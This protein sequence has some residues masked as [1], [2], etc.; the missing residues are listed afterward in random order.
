MRTIEFLQKLFPI[1]GEN[2]STLSDSVRFATIAN[3]QRF[4]GTVH[5][6]T[7]GQIHA[8][9]EPGISGLQF[10]TIGKDVY[11]TPHG[12][13][14]RAI[15][16]TKEDAVELFNVAWVE[17]D[18]E[19]INPLNFK[20]HPSFVVNTSPGR[21]HLYWLLEEPLPAREVERL[22]YRL[23]YGHNLK[24]DK[25][26]WGITKWLR[27]PGAVSYKRS[28][29]HPVTLVYD[30]ALLRYTLEDFNDLQEAPAFLS[31]VGK[32]PPPPEEENLTNREDIF[33]KYSLPSELVDLLDRKHNDRSAALWRMYHLCYHAGLSREECYALIRGSENDKFHTEY[34]YNS[35][36]DLWKD[37]Y[38]GYRMTDKPEDT[39]ILTRLRLIRQQ[40]GVPQLD[41]NRAI[42]D[43]IFRDLNVDGRIYFD[44]VQ[45][46]ALYY[47]GYTL[48]PIDP[49][50]RRWKTILSNR[51]W[52]T[53]G[54]SNFTSI[55]NILSHTAEDQSERVHPHAFS[56]YDRVNFI[57]YVYNG[58]GRI[59]RLD[60]KTIDLV[61]NGT[62]GVLFRDE[63]FKEPFIAAPPTERTPSLEDAVLSLPNYKNDATVHTRTD[64]IAMVRMW[65]YSL[66]FA[67]VMESRPH[68][69]ITGEPS[70]G[71]SLVFQAISEL[72]YGP[73]ST[74]TAAPDDR[75]TFETIVSNA[76]QVFFDNIDTPNKWFMDAICEVATGI[77]YTRRV[78]YTTND[79][80]SYQVKC[81][82]G[83]TTRNTWFTRAD[84]A[85]RL[86]VVHVERHHL[87]SNPTVLLDLIRNHRN[88]LWMLLLQDLNKLVAQMRYYVPEPSEHRMASFIDIVRMAS[89]SLD[90]RIDVDT[91]TD[92]LIRNQQ[93]SALQSSLIWQCL[94]VWIDIHRTDP[95]D[96]VS[97]VWPNNHR[98]ISGAVLHGELRNIALKHFSGKQYE[99]QIQS[100]RMLAQQ[101]KELIPH[102]SR[103]MSVQTRPT[104]TALQYMFTIPEE[105]LREKLQGDNYAE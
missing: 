23:A 100:V 57:L 97:I 40:K 82:L 1:S 31:S 41:K 42:A 105:K 4:P 39:P 66:F 17:L 8:I 25:G 45:K 99:E 98:W 74:V 50:N 63:G 81:Y 93:E 43:E 18:D 2:D 6:L 91:L 68:L 5:W 64:A 24:E 95:R 29:E 88:E 54:E 16:V 84:V 49:K 12:F 60:G 32:L 83:V 26:G 70:S 46:D 90:A 21:H 11:F 44:D 89:K 62:D 52:V 58:G 15:D 103:H 30:N 104:S 53:E 75:K 101:L 3:D 14:R 102:I 34:R 38:R 47:N 22:N 10:D 65:L 36:E 33:A 71:K 87:K 51:Y 79:S 61:D 73:Y 9:D 19:D 96:G 55:N 69:V 86:I 13:S 94:Q 77:Q 56:Y 78:Y 72:L 85:D 48:V 37:I 67:E 27:L 35:D 92:I 59:Y 28:E 7:R 20:P 80:I 76:H